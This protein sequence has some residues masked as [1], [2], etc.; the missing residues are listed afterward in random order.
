MRLDIGRAVGASLG[1]GDAVV[2]LSVVEVAGSDG[3]PMAAAGGADAKALVTYVVILFLA[4]SPHTMTVDAAVVANAATCAVSGIRAGGAPDHVVVDPTDACVWSLW[5]WLP[6]A[7][8]LA[9]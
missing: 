1:D 6:T 3:D 5:G 2:G 7:E 4:A 8:T 9:P